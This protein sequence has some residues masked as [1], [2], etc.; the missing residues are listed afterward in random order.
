MN[1]QET[2]KHYNNTTV[3]GPTTDSADQL[4]AEKY[5]SPGESFYDAMSRVS[6][7]LADGEDH[8]RAFKGTLLNQ[9]FLPGGRIQSSVGSPRNTTAFNCF[10]SDT[11]NDNM[12]SIM[13]GASNAAQTMRMGG[14]IGYDFSQLRPRGDR[15][16]SLDSSSSGPVSF[17][18]IYD[19]VCATI[20]SSGHR[21]GAQMGVLRVDHPDI[22]EFVRAKQII[23]SLA[24]I[25]ALV[26]LMHS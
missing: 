12:D 22:Q 4:H 2:H 16:V 6:G 24:L 14:G 3:Y 19:A 10:V 20:S 21:R 1:S 23:T 25:S 17:M 18:G 8:R 11:I 9:R 7:A 15:I 13:R 5:R 26:L